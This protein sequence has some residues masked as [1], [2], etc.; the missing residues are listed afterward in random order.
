MVGEVTEAAGNSAPR[1]MP[2]Q[3]PRLGWTAHTAQAALKEEEEGF[4]GGS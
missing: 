1:P 2:T 4:E 3:G